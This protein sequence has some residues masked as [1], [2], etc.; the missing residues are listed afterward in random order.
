MKTTKGLLRWLQDNK[1]GYYE[2]TDNDM[3]KAI[4]DFIFD[5]TGKR[6]TDE[7]D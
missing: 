2:P 7:Q 3:A 6:L 1:D 5:L 4:E